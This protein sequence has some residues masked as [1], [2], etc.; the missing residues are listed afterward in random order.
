MRGRGGIAAQAES[1]AA[2]PLVLCLAGVGLLPE[3]AWRE[4]AQRIA[5][6][7]G[8]VL[9]GSMGGLHAALVRHGAWTP[10]RA[11]VVAVPAIAAAAGIVLGGQRGLAALAVGW[12]AS[13]LLERHAPDDA[14]P[15]AYRA[16]RRRLTLVAGTLLAL[17]MVA[18]DAAGLT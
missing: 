1:L 9:L 7:W 13:W 11:L 2:A 8:G 14:L 18:S 16:L 17:V 5:I 15:G 3:P 4:L 12:G 10:A 6:A